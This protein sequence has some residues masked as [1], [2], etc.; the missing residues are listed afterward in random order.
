MNPFMRSYSSLL[1]RPLLALGLVAVALSTAR[2]DSTSFVSDDFNARNLKRPLWEFQDPEGDSGIRMVNTGTDSA[3]LQFSLPA[4]NEHDISSAGYRVPRVTQS[5]EDTDFRIEAKFLSSVVGGTLTAF[6]VQGIVIEQDANNIIRFDFTTGT[7]PNIRAYAATFVGGFGSGVT[8]INQEIVPYGTSPLWLRVER[9][10]NDWTQSYSLDGVNWTVAGTFTHAIA[11]SRVGVW[12]GNAGMRPPAYVSHVDYFVNLDNPGLPEDTL[13]DMADDT[14]PL[15]HNVRATL[16]AP[17]A[18]ELAWSTDELSTGVMNYGPTPA[19]GSTASSLVLAYDHKVFLTGLLSNTS[20]D[21][22]ITATDDSANSEATGNN[23][24]KT[25]VYKFDAATVSDDFNGTVLASPLWTP[26]DPVGDGTITVSGGT[27]SVGV[28]SGVQHDIWTSGARAPRVMQTVAAGVNI[29]EVEA[30]F[31]TGVTGNATSFQLEG[32]LVEQDSNNMI[33]F[34]FVNGSGNTKA[35]AATFA[36]GLTAPSIKIN[37]NIL[38]LGAAPLYL[39]VKQLGAQWTMEYSLDG[40][41]WT[42]AGTFWHIMQPS[43]VGVFA[44]NAGSG[45]PA[46]TSHVEYFKAVLPSPAALSS[47]ANGATELD[48]SPTLNWLPAL[49]ATAYELQVA[50]DTLFT[51]VVLSD[52]NVAGTSRVATGLNYLTKYFWRVRGKSGAGA[53]GYS[54]A[55]SFTTRTS[56]PNTPALVSPADGATGQ[57]AALTLLWRRIE[58]ATSY[59]VQVSTEGTFTTGLIVDDPAVIDT[60]K[61]LSALTL[62]TQYFWR[63]NA[64][65]PGGTSDYSP[66]SSFTTLASIPGT[67]TLLTPDNGASV[68]ASSVTFTW[69]AAAGAT[70]YWH[71]LAVDP[72][73]QFVVIDSTL[74]GTSKTTTGLIANQAY[75]WRVK[76]GNISGWGPYSEGRNFIATTVGVKEE[77]GI[78]TSFGVSQNYPNPFN[79]ATTIE[80]AVPAG[81]HVTIDVY[82]A[83]GERVATLVDEQRGAGYHTV[84]FDASS[85]PSG[86]Y[87]YRMSAGQ[88][89]SVRKM[90][91][92]K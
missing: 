14:A 25:A 79:P 31:A 72:L 46:F 47:P 58:A 4:G 74:S 91:L 51:S 23:I 48:A 27:L 30:K 26:I 40:I 9:V 60:S 21:F 89:T 11:V 54:P 64:S 52:Q 68:D 66:T 18:L 86:L 50:T 55:W 70:K 5:C 24:E 61:A 42:Q 13:M 88:F 81:A 83:I 37:T 17:N 85:L 53:G 45:A 73:F 69:Q 36:N 76:G 34:D 67:V 44:G 75:Y 33:R 80:F 65:S 63:V 71:E 77:R 57:P 84:S 43:K 32:I 8:R 3:A 10:G 19:Y 16:V 1:L 56:A 62:G 38:S 12:A 78:P 22:Q 92:M 49:G 35:F 41:S 20:Y 82:N 28:P 39:K 7:T 87:L 90:L 6:Q 29:M 59:R 2:A 15:V